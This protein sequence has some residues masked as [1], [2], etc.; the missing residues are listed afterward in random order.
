MQERK[1]GMKNAIVGQCIALISVQTLWMG[2]LAML[3][4]FTFGGSK[5]A[6]LLV[7]S[8]FLIGF[9]FSVAVSLKPIPKDRLRFMRRNFFFAAL[10]LFLGGVFLIVAPL[11]WMVWGFITSIVFCRAFAGRSSVF[12]FPVLQDIVPEASR[13]S[14][15][16]TLRAS[17]TLG[18]LFVVLAVAGILDRISG[19]ED[20]LGHKKVVYGVLVILLSLFFWARNF[21]LARMPQT[22]P[23]L[24]EQEEKKG[25]R[26]FFA[27]FFSEEGYGKFIVYTLVLNFLACLSS[28]LLTSMMKDLNYAEGKI[29]KI[30][31]LGTIGSVLAFLICKNLVDRVRP[32]LIFGLTHL[33][34]GI[35]LLG[36]S[37][38][39]KVPFAQEYY[40]I[41]LNMVNLGM[42][43]AFDLAVVTYL[44]QLLTGTNRNLCF[45]L[46][47][48]LTGITVTFGNLFLGEILER[49]PGFFQVDIM[50]INQG[51]FVASAFVLFLTLP[52]VK[53]VK[54]GSWTAQSMVKD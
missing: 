45:S 34:I 16:S 23:S 40:L 6:A 25:W 21:F 52:L 39:N 1:Q 19:P 15:F 12:W 54:A 36:L 47:T 27:V 3:I 50:R 38:Y 29:M 20:S 28:P 35:T 48:A 33:F 8:T 22:E 10:S 5:R 51:I 14:F 13:G 7:Q 30:N 44:F 43:S 31:M 32:R 37:C 2:G 9:V 49:G 18:S 24:A 26:E 53:L 4:V 11:S 46:F 41:F 17:W 42:R